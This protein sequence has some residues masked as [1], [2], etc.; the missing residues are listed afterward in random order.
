MLREMQSLSTALKNSHS[1][2]GKG[3][4]T[5]KPC[6]FFCTLKILHTTEKYLRKALFLQ[7]VMKQDSFLSHHLLKGITQLCSAARRAQHMFNPSDPS[8]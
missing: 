6:S 2:G 3:I 8:Q 1:L 4:Q 5:D 7:L